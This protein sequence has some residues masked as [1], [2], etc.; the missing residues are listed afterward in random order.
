M[1]RNSAVTYIQKTSIFNKY[2]VDMYIN[3]IGYKYNLGFD[4]NVQN[5]YIYRDLRVKFFTS[6]NFIILKTY[7]RSIAHLIT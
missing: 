7:V 3:T 4:R 2:A 1:C 6:L 5:S